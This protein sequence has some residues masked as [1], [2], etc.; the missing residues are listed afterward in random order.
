MNGRMT[1]GWKGDVSANGRAD[2][3]H[4]VW[5]GEPMGRGDVIIPKMAPIKARDHGGGGEDHRSRAW[6]TVV[7]A[8]FWCS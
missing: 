7:D 6:Y 3:G 2:G 8:Y 1:L 5:R 4:G